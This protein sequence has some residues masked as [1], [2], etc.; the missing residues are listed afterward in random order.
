[1]HNKFKKRNH[2]SDDIEIDPEKIEEENNFFDKIDGILRN[3]K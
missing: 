2:L 3:K 1:M